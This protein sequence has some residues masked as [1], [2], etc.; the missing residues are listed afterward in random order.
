MML[1][2]IQHGRPEKFWAL[3]GF[4]ATRLAELFGAYPDARIIWMHRDPVQVIASR[5]KMAGYIAEG[6]TGTVDWAEQARIHLA[7]CRAGF[8]AILDN[9][10]VRDP[11][12]HHARYPDFTRDPVGTIRGFCAFAGRPWTAAAERAMRDYLASNRA[13]RYGKFVYSTDLIGEDVA[14]LHEEF[15]P[16]RARFG[17]GIEKRG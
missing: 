12:I 15:A 4:H 3:K 13:D 11:R 10:W 16:Y 17:I 2:H 6:L 7:A 5:I 1:Q 9:P 14:A 8:Q